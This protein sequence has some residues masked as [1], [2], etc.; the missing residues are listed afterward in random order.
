MSRHEFINDDGRWKY[1]ENHPAAERIL[2]GSEAEK[3]A[4]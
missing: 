2:A 1:N 4:G 3:T